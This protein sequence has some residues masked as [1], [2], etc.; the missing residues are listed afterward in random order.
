MKIDNSHLR[1]LALTTQLSYFGLNPSEW[2]IERLNALKYLVQN[3]ADRSFSFFGQLE[4][5]K[6]KPTWKSLDL[7]SI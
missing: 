5:R 3:K 6:K 7:I 4:Y 2:S 1:D